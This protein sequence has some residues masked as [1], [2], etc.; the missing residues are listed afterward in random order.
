MEASKQ[1]PVRVNEAWDDTL[2]FLAK[3][4]V[5]YGTLKDVSNDETY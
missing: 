1:N 5:D 2:S 3:I 4:I